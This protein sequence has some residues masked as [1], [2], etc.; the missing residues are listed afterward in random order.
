[1]DKN[2]RSRAGGSQMDG[3]RF[4]GT[5]SLSRATLRRPGRATRRALLS[6]SALAGAALRGV[7]V[8]AGIA[9]S[10][11]VAWAVE[12]SNGGAGPNPA[13]ADN[14]DATNT[15]CGATANAA[16]GN[17]TAVGNLTRAN[18]GGSTAVGGEAAGLGAN[19]T[20]IGDFSFV[21]G[22]Y[23]TGVGANSFT[24]GSGAT[25]VGGGGTQGALGGGA[26]SV[27]V[28][29]S[30]TSGS[31]FGA[32]AGGDASIAIGGTNG[33]GTAAN[34]AG[35]ASIAIGGADGAGAGAST[36]FAG[37]INAIAIGGS[38]G[39]GAGAAASANGSI[40]LGGATGGGAGAAA[41]NTN[42]IAIGGGDASGNHGAVASGLN[43]LAIG[44]GAGLFFGA[45]AVGDYSV[46]LGP[47]GD[48]LAV[49]PDRLDAL[50]VVERAVVGGAV[51]LAHVSPVAVPVADKG[52]ANVVRL[53]PLSG[54]RGDDER[55]EREER[56]NGEY[57]FGHDCF[58]LADNGKPQAAIRPCR[59][60]PGG[61]FG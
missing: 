12:C 6:T 61:G 44:S 10:P 13:G 30:S 60:T 15:A 46:S 24:V 3:N 5:D 17:A 36:G 51:L 29:G 56:S 48:A 42:A 2:T 57:G 19:S 49:A 23:S 31:G 28:G 55:S 53:N 26:A 41:S 20:A 27:A 21:Q 43:S 8:A 14:G 39:A 50:V 47:E 34:T 58:G 59:N 33:S 9:L 4:S 22:A 25:A 18:A 52:A 54:P 38:T 37:T 32:G 40:A 1:M 35:T 16:G 11:T 45:Q 7:V